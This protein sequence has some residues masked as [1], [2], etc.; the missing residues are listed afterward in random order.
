MSQRREQE[1][2]LLQE[3]AVEEKQELLAEEQTTNPFEPLPV[4]YFYNADCDN[5]S[6]PSTTYT[7][8][9]TKSSSIITNPSEPTRRDECLSTIP[10]TESDELIKSS[11]ENLV[12]TPS[13]SEDLSKDL[14]DIESECNFDSLLEEFFGELAH[15]NLIPPGINEADFDPEEKFGLVEKLLYENSS[16]QPPDEFNSENFDAIK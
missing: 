5:I 11:V 10:E 7:I 13:E 12:P 9:L 2:I 6:T 4:S 15:I 3:Q 16:P 14:S 1:A 8:H